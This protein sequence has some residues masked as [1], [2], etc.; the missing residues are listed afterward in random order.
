MSVPCQ[1]GKIVIFASLVSWR[2][3]KP[4]GYDRH[5][6]L[7]T[8]APFAIWRPLFRKRILSQAKPFCAPLEKTATI[9]SESFRAAMRADLPAT[10][11][12]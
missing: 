7:G 4:S 3:S 9:E 2:M 10:G 5:I 8:L 6:S 1:R 12:A 11:H